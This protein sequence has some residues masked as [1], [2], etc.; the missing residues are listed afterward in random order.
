M[1]IMGATF[2]GK[3]VVVYNYI[4][5]IAPVSYKQLIVNLTIFLEVTI[6]II[7]ACYYQFISKDHIYLLYIGMT[8]TAFCLIYACIFYYESP[9]YYHS[10]ARYQEARAV[11]KD[12]ARFNGVPEA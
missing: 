6:I 8:T 11:L 3:H 4:L 10:K 9:S 12:M 2:P 7:M 5:E 1:I